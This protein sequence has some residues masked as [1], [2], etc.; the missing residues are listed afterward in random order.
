MLS[1]CIPIYNVDVSQLA[2][3][4]SEQIFRLEVPAEALFMDDHSEEKYRKINRTISTLKD[5]QY[6]E[7]DYNQGRSSIRNMLGKSAGYPWL[8]FLDG[9]SMLPDESFLKNYIHAIPSA[10]VIC[11]GTIYDPVPPADKNFRLRWEYGIHRE[12]LTAQQRTRTGKFAITAN[13]FL[14]D[15]DIFLDTGFRE[16]IRQYGHED[17]VLG[18]DLFLKGI[19]IR[20]IDNPVIHSGL[21]PSREYLLKTKSALQNLLFIKDLLITD[22]LFTRSSGLLLN[23][24]KLES[25]RLTRFGA[26]AFSLFE[27]YLTRNLTGK[28]PSLFLFDVFRLG[29]LCRCRVHK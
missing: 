9:D 28:R 8:L 3:Q 25:F 12:Q 22:P 26:A 10:P 11:G 7:L 6:T 20:H 2:H 29:Y 1:V 19:L 24:E 14:I 13:N 16:A 18:Y 23:L 5:I 15:R 4:L 27:P 17:T 21:E